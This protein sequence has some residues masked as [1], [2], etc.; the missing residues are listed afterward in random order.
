MGYLINK[1]KELNLKGPNGEWAWYWVDD[2]GSP[3][4]T[5]AT[6]PSSV[7]PSSKAVWPLQRKR[8]LQIA[9]FIAGKGPN[10]GR[11]FG[12]RRGN[13]SKAHPGVDLFA[14][15]GD[16]VVAVDDGT[17]VNFYHFTSGVFALIVDHG[18]YVVNYGEVDRNSLNFFGLKTPR[19][20]DGDIVHG[21]TT[22]FFTSSDSGATKKY[23]WLA[24]SGSSVKAGDPIAYVGKMK[25]SSMLHFELYSSGIVNKVWTGFPN[26]PPPSGLLD[27]TDFLLEL[28]RRKKKEYPSQKETNISQIQRCR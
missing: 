14:K 10:G 18:S 25:K 5:K 6:L 8:P 4:F 19:F 22:R 7:V 3:R 16:I 9:R 20:A 13:G 28:T 12:Y 26:S 23:P 21:R 17:I 11:A 24:A 27:P 15:Y 2:G 1:A